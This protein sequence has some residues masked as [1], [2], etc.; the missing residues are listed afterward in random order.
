MTA[1]AGM[2][3][4]VELLLLRSTLNARIGQTG[5]PVSYTLKLWMSA[6]ISAGVA[7][8]VKIAVPVSQ[9]ILAAVLIIGPY[10]VVFFAM[11]ALLRI[12]ETST[13]LARLRK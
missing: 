11:T 7:W 6:A 2:A 8:A 4:W 5:L 13:M 9:P 3:G 1:S 12:P 10:G